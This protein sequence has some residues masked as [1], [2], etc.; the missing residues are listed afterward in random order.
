MLRGHTK[1]DLKM[2]QQLEENE[3]HSPDGDPFIRMAS[4]MLKELLYAKGDDRL[5]VLT[6]H[7]LVERAVA[8]VLDNAAKRGRKVAALPHSTKLLLANEM[9]IMPD[10][11]YE[12]L[13]W[14]RRLRNKA[15]HEPY[16]SLTD[17]HR[18]HLARN[19]YFDLDM[20]ALTYPDGEAK[21]EDLLYHYSFFSIFAAFCISEDARS[22]DADGTRE[23]EG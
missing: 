9:G 23:I 2:L 14:F 10:S 4:G 11:S 16:F 5:M 3:P 15:A 21:P 22:P 18:T 20:I 7:G 13:D 17:K 8:L 6:A 12:E 1:H 19:Q